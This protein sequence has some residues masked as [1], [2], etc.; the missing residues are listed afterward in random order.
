[1]TSIPIFVEELHSLLEEPAL[2]FYR[3]C[4]SGNQNLSWPQLRNDMQVRFRDYRMDNVIRLSLES[5]KQKPGE[6]FISFYNSILNTSSTLRNPL[7]QNDLIFLLMENMRASQVPSSVS[8]LV[9]RC[10]Y[11]EHTWSRLH[12]Q[13]NHRFSRSFVNEISNMHEPIVNPDDNYLHVYFVLCP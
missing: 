10:V 2:E 9:Q 11:A 7:S 3:S 4:R 1:M 5:R 6:A 8:E 12:S 13:N